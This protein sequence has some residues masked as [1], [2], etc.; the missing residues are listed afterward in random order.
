M[1][2]K[3]T[4]MRGIV[5]ALVALSPVAAPLVAQQVASA[6]PDGAALYRQRC[7]MCHGN[8]PGKKSPLGPNLVG[9]V[10]RKAGSTDFAYSPAMKASGITWSEPVIERY[11]ASPPAMVPGS[12]MTIAVSDAKQ[13]AALAGYLATLK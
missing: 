1:T 3:T 5:L 10:G 9:V 2:S 12:K 11:L 7:I 6:G 4:P 8:V 13:R